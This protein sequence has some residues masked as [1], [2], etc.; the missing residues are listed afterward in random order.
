MEE[1]NNTEPAVARKKEKRSP[2]LFI[3]IG[4]FLILAVWI[5]INLSAGRTTFFGRASTTGVFNPSNSYV[6]ASPLT[7]RVGGDKIRITVFVLDGQGR[8]IPGSSVT[9]GC[10]DEVVCQNAGLSFE[11]VQAG[12]DNLGQAI[13]DVSSPVRGKYELQARIGGTSIPQTVTVSFQ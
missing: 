9:V 1:A 4:L 10:V 11:P 12:S 13:Y 3:I 2:V 5:V 7:A 6:F 8:G